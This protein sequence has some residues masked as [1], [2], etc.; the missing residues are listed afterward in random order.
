[1]G[2]TIPIPDNDPFYQPP[3]GFESSPP[4]TIF[5]NRTAP[6]GITNVTAMQI[7]YRTTDVTTNPIA[8]V[9]TIL[10]GPLS[11]GDKLVAFND[12]EDSANTTCAP[13]YLFSTGSGNVIFGPTPGADVPLGLANGWTIV[14]ADYEGFG[15]AFAAGHLEGHAVLD[16]LRAALN[17]GPAGIKKNATLGSYGYSGGAIAT[18]QHAT[19]IRKG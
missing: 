16:G 12:F 10:K 9:A 8:T 7:L 19:F 18:G 1:M 13:S 14:I 6:S 5:K 2:A 15:S 4:G 11:T 17:Y 3:P